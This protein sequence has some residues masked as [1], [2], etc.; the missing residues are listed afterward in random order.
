MQNI[1]ELVRKNIASMQPYSSARDEFTGSE[2]IFLDANENPFGIYNR[3][4]DPKQQL[5]KKELAKLKKVSEENI[6]LGNGSDEII[7][8]LFRIFCEPGKDTAITFSPTYGMYKVAA[9]INDVAL[10]DIALDEGF[11]IDFDA[12]EKIIAEHSPKLVFICSPNNPTG[13]TL[14][15][16]ERLITGFN[17]IVV[18]DEAYID[19]SPH[20]SYVQS[21]LTL[22]NVVV[23][24]TLS[25]AW[26]LAGA[27]IGMAF[28]NTEMIA[29]LNK[30]KPPYNIS[31][32]NQKAAVEALQAVATF[33]TNKDIILAE[34]QRMVSALTA[35]TAVV[36]IFPSDA[37]FILVAFSNADMVYEYLIEKGIITRNRN[38][39][40][41]NAI[42]ITVGSSAENDAAF[43]ALKNMP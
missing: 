11:Q 40:V 5:V 10:L 34:K 35:L 24:Q 26:G 12:T 29:L 13:N 6:F 3:Y 14:V 1:K 36:K 21:A 25:K 16:I 17:G 28:A 4:P 9:A 42:R 32:L 30:V 39:V 20:E 31:L 19:F 8:L 22:P 2:G 43:D 33:Q 41:K 37:N 23:M 7:D 38:T 18:I 15:N 27:R